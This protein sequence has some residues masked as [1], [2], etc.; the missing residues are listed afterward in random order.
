VAGQRVQ[1]LPLRYAATGEGGWPRVVDRAAL[2]EQ[3]RV[4]NPNRLVWEG[5]RESFALGRVAPGRYAIVVPAS[6]EQG[7]LTLA[8]GRG[9]PVLD[10]PIDG[11]GE[12]RAGERRLPFTL[13]I[14]VQSLTIGSEGLG[15]PG[16]EEVRLVALDLDGAYPGD[17]RAAH[18]AERYGETLVFFLSGGVYPEPLGFWASPRADVEVMLFG[19]RSAFPIVLGNGAR[20]NKVTLEAGRWRQTVSL[21]P[22]QQMEVNVPV[23]R[24][25]ESTTLRLRAAD[26]FV[27][28]EH[29]SQ[30]RD[31]RRLGVWVQP[32]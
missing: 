22:Y 27:P 19:N 16:F 24:R 23:A 18:R 31:H 29:D 20:A 9:R 5:A 15:A 4:A 10:W 25:G 30:S 8:I 32:R 17:D 3:L 13:P 12:G 14:G 26:G 28:S 11:P 6:E 2:L 7:T 1:G 21:G